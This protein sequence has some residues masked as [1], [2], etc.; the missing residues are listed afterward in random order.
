MFGTSRTPRS[1]WTKVPSLG[2]SMHART[3]RGSM[4]GHG[5]AP[6]VLVHGL[7]LSSRYMVPLGRRLA[8]GY[9]VL[10][11]DLPGF[12][13]SPPPAGAS[14]PAGPDVREQA[15]HLLAWMDACGIQRAV[16]FGNSV[17]VQVVVDVAV[18]FPERVER[19]ILT[20]PTP[21][22]RYRTP[23][24]QYPLVVMNMPFELPSLNPIMQADY[25]SAGIP[26]MIQQLRRTVGDP[27]ETRLPDVQAPAL[28]V[29]GEHD[30][31]LSQEWAEEFTRLLPNGRLVVVEGAAH[32]VHYSAAQI[33][34]RLV[35]SFLQGQLDWPL[36]APADGTVVPASD[37]RHDPLA[38]TKPISTLAHG[39]LDYLTA[40]FC[41][42]VPRAMGWGPRTE[43]LLAMNGLMA[44][45]YSLFT[46]YELGA[47]RKLP[48][49]VHL[50]MD[51]G[52]GVN[53]LLAAATTLRGEPAAGRVAV[54]ALGLFHLFAASATQVPMGPA[55]LVPVGG[56]PVLGQTGAD[57]EAAPVR[58]ERARDMATT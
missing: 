13:S 27:I 24:R 39:V 57:Q 32:N 8:L 50:N 6:I 4:E 51:A 41:L 15:D 35:H 52:S 49:T 30:M 45:S 16:L 18:R 5:K 46:D 40:A 38:P 28:V 2:I 44:T 43:K 23:A 33:T 58:Q 17:G 54:A 55:R 19:L 31:T 26:R 11:P 14:W 42:T 53:L 7:G 20:G 25:A 56:Q 10:A 37:A 36:P 22:P 47:A 9:D 48:M 34:A 21:D 12:G 29:R 1:V 3:W